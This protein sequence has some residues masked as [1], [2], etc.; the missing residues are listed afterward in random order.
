MEITRYIWEKKNAKIFHWVAYE[1]AILNPSC[2]KMLLPHI[3]PCEW[4]A[5]LKLHYKKVVSLTYALIEILIP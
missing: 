4:K 3:L 2:K 5:T 1:G